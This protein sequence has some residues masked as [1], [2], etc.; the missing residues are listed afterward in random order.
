MRERHP[1]RHQRREKRPVPERAPLPED[2]DVK[3]RA[4]KEEKMEKRKLKEQHRRMKDALKGKGV[5]REKTN[6]IDATSQAVIEHL[7]ALQV[8]KTKGKN[9]QKEPQETTSLLH[10]ILRSKQ[11][12]QQGKKGRRTMVTI[13][14]TNPR[15]PIPVPEATVTATA[16]TVV[17]KPKHNKERQIIMS[18][19]SASNELVTELELKADTISRL[20]LPGIRD[21]R[22][23]LESTRPTVVVTPDRN[24]VF[25]PTPESITGWKALPRKERERVLQE[26]H[27]AL[28]QGDQDAW[29]RAGALKDKDGNAIL[30]PGTL[31]EANAQLKHYQE[32]RDEVL[33]KILTERVDTLLRRLKVIEPGTRYDKLGFKAQVLEKGQD[34]RISPPPAEEQLPKGVS[35]KSTYTPSGHPVNIRQ[36]SRRLQQTSHAPLQQG[37][38]RALQGKEPIL[39]H[40]LTLEEQ[41]RWAGRIDEEEARRAKEEGYSEEDLKLEIDERAELEHARNVAEHAEREAEREARVLLEAKRKSKGE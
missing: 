27:A 18:P 30:S 33:P 21:L 31:V 26:I 8:P 11:E 41:Q 14:I 28:R 6:K 20:D 1:E 38:Q 24:F 40:P 13:A 4:R 36:G 5:A 16:H 37:D 29:E 10:R 32:E 25:T 22:G 15:D 7:Q 19:E 3:A 2:K 34:I 35:V 12:R 9:R 39:L 17:G 23:A